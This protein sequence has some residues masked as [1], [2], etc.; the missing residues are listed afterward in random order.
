M[1]WLKFIYAAVNIL[2]A[3]FF[4]YF[5]FSSLKEQ[6]SRA[7]II[8]LIMAFVFCPI[9]TLLFFLPE[10]LL[11]L[12]LSGVTTFLILYFVP[13]GKMTNLKIGKITDKVDERNVIFSREEYHEGDK[14]YEAYYAAHPDKKE[15]DDRM[16]RLPEL[17]EPGGKYYNEKDATIIG[18]IFG[19][20]ESML[21]DVD[22]PVCESVAPVKQ[23]EIS[24]EIKKM[25]RR[26]GAV[27]VGIAELNPQYIYS[28]VGRGPEPWGQPIENNHKYAIMFALEMDY[29]HVEQAPY[30]GITYESALQ[31]LRG[32]NI[33][34][35]IAKF[36]RSLGY[37]ARAHIAGSNYQIM[38][39]PIAY[40][41]GLGELGRMGYLISPK[42]GPRV[43]LGAITTDLPLNID[44]PIN[45]GVQDFCKR[46][47]KCANICPSAA[48][49]KS[50]KINVRGVEKWQLDIEKCLH[51]WRLIGTDCGLCMKVCPYSHPST[52]SH[53]AVRAGISKST[54][55]QTVSLW[56]DDFFYGKR[57]RI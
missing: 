13:I 9:L 29:D 42:F 21:E 6:K 23:N 34:I 43:R 51:F 53:N 11:I 14:K 22:G 35:A 19:A 20:I 1:F 45:F 18:S 54:F 2:L 57:P 15:I 46:C 30:C 31:Y 47:K 16:R 50:E 24:D 27:D 37:P 39:P 41:A 38:L 17:I 5:S 28:H 10:W 26:L 56:G 12:Y 48:I 32:A 33:S 52:L 55:A 8:S 25:I 3:L 40:D 36:I 49:P 44:A 7:M 4:L